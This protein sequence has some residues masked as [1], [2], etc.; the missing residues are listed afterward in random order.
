M[1]RCV[2]TPAATPACCGGRAAKGREPAA[3]AR[4]ASLLLRGLSPRASAPRVALGPASPPARSPPTPTAAARRQFCPASPSCCG[5]LPL[6]SSGSNETVSPGIFH[7]C[8]FFSLSRLSH[9]L[10]LLKV[11]GRE[12]NLIAIFHEEH[13]RVL[14]QLQVFTFFPESLPA[15]KKPF[16]RKTIDRQSARKPLLGL[17][18]YMLQSEEL[19]AS[20][21]A[22][23][24]PEKLF[25]AERNFN[26]AQDLDVSLLEGDLVGVI[27]KKDPMGSQNRWLID[28]GGK[29]LKQQVNGTIF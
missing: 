4:G 20:L 8:F 23:Y 21:L 28:N 16:E 19:R 7:L 22:R 27:K 25:Q 6:T 2:G 26:A 12:G 10:Q 29:N 9:G 18:S 24:P 5:L 13:S 17:P 14:Q 15:T 1:S 3:A 11:A